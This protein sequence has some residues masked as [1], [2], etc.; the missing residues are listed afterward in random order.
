[1]TERST[2]S[3]PPEEIFGREGILLC[4]SLG[5]PLKL[6]T[7]KSM[8][9]GMYPTFVEIF[10]DGDVSASFPKTASDRTSDEILWFG[11][12]AIRDGLFYQQ[13]NNIFHGSLE[14]T[15]PA[16][17]FDHVQ[18]KTGAIFARNLVENTPL[19]LPGTV[20]PP[21]FAEIDW[22]EVLFLG[23]TSTINTSY[24]EHQGILDR[25]IRTVMEVNPGVRA[26]HTLD[27]I[28]TG[29]VKK[30]PNVLA[31][32]TTINNSLFDTTLA[33]EYL[34]ARTDALTEGENPDCSE[35]DKQTNWN[36]LNER[37]LTPKY[38]ALQ[39][40]PVAVTSELVRNPQNHGKADVILHTRF[41][42]MDN[43]QEA[44]QLLQN[45]ITLLRPGGGLLLGTPISGEKAEVLGS[46][47]VKQIMNS[48]WFDHT[49]GLMTL[50][51]QNNLPYPVFS[52][53]VKN[54][55]KMT[56]PPSHTIFS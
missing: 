30:N 37:V 32:Y 21:S 15:L 3:Y 55:Y 20:I 46:G 33:V 19:R 11:Q 51:D 44:E 42:P 41:T 45:Y 35:L 43:R 47:F 18:K 6:I 17:V 10:S 14:T 38:P 52:F 48:G 9:T 13:M 40:D 24:R 56:P 4:H 25:P 50:P 5:M 54:P 16:R 49:S 53:F 1:M 7:A 22:N 8:L 36:F 12:E 31:S 26:I 2:R 23:P 34:R 28:M 39:G 27:G 29:L